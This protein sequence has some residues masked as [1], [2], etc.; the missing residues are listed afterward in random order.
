MPGA[1]VEAAVTPSV[2][3]GEANAPYDPMILRVLVV[4]PT[5]PGDPG[6]VHPPAA[7]PLTSHADASYADHTLVPA[8]FRLS[9]QQKYPPVLAADVIE[10]LAGSSLP[11]GA[12][13]RAW[14]PIARA[15]LLEVDHAPSKTIAGPAFVEEE[16]A[17][18]PPAIFATL[19]ML[20]LDA[21]PPSSD[22]LTADAALAL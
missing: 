9:P 19:P 4:R 3:T 16:T 22:N 2:L 21:K 6:A 1:V 18:L 12:P 14:Q 7:V 17:W 15:Q 13:F 11:R 10:F 8:T 5:I 20:V